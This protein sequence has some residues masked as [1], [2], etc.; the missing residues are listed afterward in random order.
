[1]PARQS[2]VWVSEAT[3]CPLRVPKSNTVT[4][5]SSIPTFK[6]HTSTIQRKLCVKLKNAAHNGSRL[7]KPDYNKIFYLGTIYGLPTQEWAPGVGGEADASRE[8]LQADGRRESTH[9]T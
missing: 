1:M 9:H 6:G 3:P 7:E 8:H 2:L 4:R 5:I